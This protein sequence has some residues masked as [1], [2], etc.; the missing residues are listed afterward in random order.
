[1]PDDP[2]REPSAFTLA[3][4]RDMGNKRGKTKVSFVQ[5]AMD[6]TFGS[7]RDVLQKVDKS[8][9]PAPKLKASPN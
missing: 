4:T 6:Q 5:V 1:M 7:Y 9:A 8:V 2:R 3:L